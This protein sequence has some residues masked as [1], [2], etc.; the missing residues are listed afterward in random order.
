MTWSRRPGAASRA[1]VSGGGDGEDEP[2]HGLIFGLD[3]RE[4]GRDVL[5]DVGDRYHQ[6]CFVT[7]SRIW[8]VLGLGAHWL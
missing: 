2:T 4:E 6:S 3:G 5:L 1:S 8:T 7:E